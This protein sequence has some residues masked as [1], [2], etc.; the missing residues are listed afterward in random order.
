MGGW[1]KKARTVHTLTLPSELRVRARRPS[2]LS[3]LGSAGFPTQLAVSVWKLATA[4]GR[5]NMEKHEDIQ[6]MVAEITEFCRHTLVDIEIRDDGE[7]DIQIDD[8]G[9]ATGVANVNDIPD[10][11]KMHLF[12]FARGMEL[13]DEEKAERPAEKGVVPAEDLAS[14][15]ENGAGEDAGRG[16]VEVQ[17]AAVDAGRVAAGASVGD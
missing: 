10:A 6:Q 1:G 5:L 4:Q 15:P 2:I 12:L 7:T 11:D 17:P 13:G 3:M 16:G 8:D 14:F 9:I